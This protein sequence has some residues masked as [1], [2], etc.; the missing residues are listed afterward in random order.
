MT[1]DH[2]EVKTALFE[3]QTPEVWTPSEG[4]FVPFSPQSKITFSTRQK[5]ITRPLGFQNGVG[6]LCTTARCVRDHCDEKGRELQRQTRVSG[7]REIGIRHERGWATSSS[8]ERKWAGES[9]KQLHHWSLW[10]PGAAATHQ[11][12]RKSKNKKTNGDVCRLQLYFSHLIFLWHVLSYHLITLLLLFPY[13]SPVLPHHACLHPYPSLHPS[14]PTLS[15]GR[16]AA[17]I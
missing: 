4:E 6:L 17:Q 12:V 13:S 10:S 16:Y 11:E 15:G 2:K 9:S 8:L 1:V 14:P 7:R 5:V 3:I